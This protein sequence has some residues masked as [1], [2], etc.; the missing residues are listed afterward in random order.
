MTSNLALLTPV[1]WDLLLAIVRWRLPSRGLLRVYYPCEQ[2]WKARL[3]RMLLVPEAKVRAHASDSTDTIEARA[4]PS[5]QPWA[6]V[7]ARD[8]LYESYAAAVAICAHSPIAFWLAPLLDRP[9]TRCAVLTLQDTW[10]DLRDMW[11]AHMD[12]PAALG[13]AQPPPPRKRASH[14]PFLRVATRAVGR[15][16]AILFGALCLLIWNVP[17]PLLSHLPPSPDLLSPV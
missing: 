13:T 14:S 6:V 8:R 10:A 15:V 17:S 11:R 4:E 2:E 12:S 16:V 9:G 3:V 7:D 5:E 1:F